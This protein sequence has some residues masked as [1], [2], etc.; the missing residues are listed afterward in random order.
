M[1]QRNQLKQ[2]AHQRSHAVCAEYHT[3]LDTSEGGST[4]S[5][6]IDNTVTTVGARF[7]EQQACRDEAATAGK[8]ARTWRSAMWA[9]LRAIATLAPFV[10]LSPSS[11]TVWQL[12]KF[13]GDQRALAIAREFLDRVTRDAK[14][15]L[16]KGL[17]S[18]VLDD[19]PK[20]IAGLEA[21]RQARKD[22][23]RRYTAAGDAIRTA[24]AEADKATK[25]VHTIFGQSDPVA[26]KKFKTAKRI[27][28]ATDTPANAVTPATT[29]TGPE[30][31]PTTP[32][33]TPK[34]A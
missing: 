8:D 20:Q 4:A 7:A 1:N 27:G 18:K 13:A 6:T 12:P 3:I 34:I 15:F 2:D 9:A 10:D 16:A 5:A 17:P 31:G 22:A 19:L 14:A 29:P 32:P 25:V 26:A 30:P 21:A 23:L 24:Q 11:A 33:A 28:P